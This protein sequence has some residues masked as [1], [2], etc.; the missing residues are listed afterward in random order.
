MQESDFSQ[1]LSNI[2]KSYDFEMDK[3]NKLEILK[4]A[5]D[6]EIDVKKVLALVKV[7]MTVLVLLYTFRIKTSKIVS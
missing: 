5:F 1:Y 4:Q 6:N 2:F 3:K 7:I